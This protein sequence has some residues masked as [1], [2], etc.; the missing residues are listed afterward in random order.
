MSKRRANMTD[1][2]KARQ[3]TEFNKMSASE[4]IDRLTEISTQLRTL[5]AYMLAYGRD[6][7]EDMS[8]ITDELDTLFDTYDDTMHL[9][10]KVLTEMAVTHYKKRRG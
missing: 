9:C 6:W 4:V 8:F 1:I 7:N 3:Y 10:R 2:V 5:Q